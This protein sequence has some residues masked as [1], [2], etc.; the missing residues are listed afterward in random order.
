MPVY[1][2]LIEAE[3]VSVRD[4]FLG[5]GILE[6]RRCTGYD[7][8]RLP[9]INEERMRSL[10]SSGCMVL[11]TRS[12]TRT[13]ITSETAQVQRGDFIIVAEHCGTGATRTFPAFRR[14]DYAFVMRRPV[15]GERVDEFYRN[16]SLYM[17]RRPTGIPNPTSPPPTPPATFKIEYINS[18]EGVLRAIC[19]TPFPGHCSYGSAINSPIANVL[20]VSHARG[21]GALTF[22]LRGNDDAAEFYL[23][24]LY[25]YANDGARPQVTSREMRNVAATYIRICGC[26]I[27]REDRFLRYL[28]QIFGNNVTVVAPKHEDFF[29]EYQLSATEEA[30]QQ[31]YYY[32]FMRYYFSVMR[33]ERLTGRRLKNQLIDLFVGA[34]FTDILGNAVPRSKWEEW[35]P[36]TIHGPAVETQYSCSN[37]IDDQWGGSLSA[38]AR[39][40]RHVERRYRQVRRT[41]FTSRIQLGESEDPPPRPRSRQYRPRC[42]EILSTGLIRD[43][44]MRVNYPSSS[45]PYRAFQRWGY[46][47]LDSFIRDLNWDFSW[48]RRSRT[49]TSIGWLYLYEVRIPITDAPLTGAPGNLLINAFLDTGPRE[50]L[51]RCHGILETDTR[52]FGRV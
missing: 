52:L 16:A 24:H 12:G 19:A 40:A 48:E 50:Y 29:G 51:S 21:E 46:E 7:A 36:E 44:V 5:M 45:F 8:S 20:L 34:G 6:V 2:V 37:P 26:N 35:I 22:K 39:F 15:P 43:P 11:C 10:I 42:M 47:S 3:N 18:L 33:K 4:F 17:G 31:T 13:N 9:D 25:L 1:P 41:L 23:D 38:S 49:L 27:G 32:E 14:T 30:G 28:K